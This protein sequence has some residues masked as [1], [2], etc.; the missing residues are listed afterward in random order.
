MTTQ[1]KEQ[2]EKHNT[3]S[4]APSDARPE[5]SGEDSPIPQEILDQIPE[6]A[7]T[8]IIETMVGVISTGPM[9]NPIVNKIT[10][11]HITQIINNNESQSQRTYEA[12]NTG[13]KY[14]LGYALLGS[15]LLSAF[16]YITIPS[17]PEF[18]EQILETIITLVIG[19]VGGWGLSEYRRR[20]RSGN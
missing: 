3:P 17:N 8:Q 9:Q 12:Q 13:R 10:S 18:F 6:P 19:G 15:L 7:R 4:I 20:S 1:D 11:E 2:L 5:N 14:S 16:A